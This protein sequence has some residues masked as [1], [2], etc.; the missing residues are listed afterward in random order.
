[1]SDATATPPAVPE[2]E[3]APEP[4]SERRTTPV[5]LLWDLVFVFAITQVTTLF[6][7]RTGWERLGEALLVLALVWWAWSAFVWAANVQEERSRT[8]RACLLAGTVLIFIV[9]LAVPSAF[10][11][12]SLLFA[13]AYALVRLAGGR[14]HRLRRTGVADPGTTAWPAAGGRGPLR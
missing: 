9:G 11:G 1:V 6:A 2:A 5:E 8:L 12:S 3:P 14:R 13:V 10:A 4:A 7:R